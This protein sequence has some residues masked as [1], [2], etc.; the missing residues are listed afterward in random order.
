MRITPLFV[1]VLICACIALGACRCG[2]TANRAVDTDVHT[3]PPR[4]EAEG[5]RFDGPRVGFER[6]LRGDIDGNGFADLTVSR[7]D[8]PPPIDAMDVY[9]VTSAGVPATPSFSLPVGS[10]CGLGQISPLRLSAFNGENGDHIAMPSPAREGQVRILRGSPD[11]TLVEAGVLSSPAHEVPSCFG[12][13]LA[14]GDRNGDGQR[15]LTVGAPLQHEEAGRVYVFQGIERGVELVPSMT[16]DAPDGAGSRFG[17]AVAMC[18][19]TGDFR[20][21]V[22]VGAPNANGRR[23]RVYA[24]DGVTG[25]EFARYDVERPGAPNP[26]DTYYE[27]GAKLLA[28]TN[29][30]ACDLVAVAG[31]V[32]LHGVYVIRGVSGARSRNSIEGP[33]LLPGTE[34]LRAVEAVASGRIDGD[35]LPDLVV[36]GSDFLRIYRSD[37][38]GL[39]MTP[40]AIVATPGDAGRGWASSASVPGD[41]DAD[42]FEDVLVGD[43][44]HAFLLFGSATGVRGA[45]RIVSPQLGTEMGRAVWVR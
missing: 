22:V 14:T 24:F 1:R 33:T 16:I 36:A 38:R 3:D 4:N 7:T 19:L 35:D 18:D 40:W 26:N 2:G 45:P 9:R 44:E 39:D 29:G 30:G 34:R 27:F 21:D 43:R 42:G 25:R 20:D 11:G 23:G 8:G 13:A 17:S 28:L 6:T 37:E 5:V 15:E 31:G 41:V 32:S 12:Q 10:G